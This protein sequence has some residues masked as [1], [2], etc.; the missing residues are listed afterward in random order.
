MKKV[1][2]ERKDIAFYIKLYPLKVHPGAYEKAKAI[3]C[4]KSLALLEDAY[5]QKPIPPP[6]CEATIID[7]NMRL[8]EKLEINSLPTLILPNGKMIPG[9]I[10]AD[11][12]KNLIGK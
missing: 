1:I 5:D 12:L 11:S 9:Y 4:Q 10:E 6:T 8:A 3:E 7:E 2:E